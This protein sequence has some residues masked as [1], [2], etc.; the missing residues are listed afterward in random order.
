MK[1]KHAALVVAVTAGL[2]AGPPAAEAQHGGKVPRLGFLVMARIPGVESAFPLGLRELGYVEGR[3]VTIEWRSADGRED[4][5]PTL[6]AELLR[7]RVDIIVAARPEARIAAMRVAST[8]PIVA[9]AGTDP[10]AEGW[11]TSFRVGDGD[12]LLVNIETDV[13]GLAR[14]FH[15]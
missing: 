5:M 10:V 11:A 15:G 12:G 14:L 3:D 7:P 1:V 13:Q 6:A 4:H 2:F 9:V 8:I